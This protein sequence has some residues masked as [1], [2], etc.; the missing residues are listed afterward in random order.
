MIRCVVFLLICVVATNA[1]VIICPPD[2][3]TIAHPTDCE[4]YY[5]CTNGDAVLMTCPTGTWFNATT[6]ECDNNHGNN[7]TGIVDTF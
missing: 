1:T 4:S 3:K 2:A 6:G 5:N 7:C